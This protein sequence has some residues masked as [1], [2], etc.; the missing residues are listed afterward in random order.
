M[1]GKTF[2]YCRPLGPTLATPDE[3]PDVHNLAIRLRVNGETMQDSNTGNM[4][5]T[6]G[7]V[8]AYISQVMTLMPGDLI[9]TGTP[10]GVGMARK[11]PVWLKGGDVVEVGNRGI[12]GAAQSGDPRVTLSYRTFGIAGGMGR[13]VGAAGLRKSQIVA[14]QGFAFHLRA[15]RRSRRPRRAHYG[16]ARRH[17][18]RF[19]SQ[20]G[21]SCKD[22]SPC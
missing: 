16:H 2:G 13:T 20:T 19:F 10:P 9:F 7:V 1:V 21:P 5:F 3:I 6:A 15:R 12:G 18:R 17:F 8:L 22:A 11:P 4:I 14:R